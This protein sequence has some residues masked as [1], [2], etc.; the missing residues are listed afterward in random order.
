M[1]SRKKENHF[2][3]FGGA[4]LKPKQINNF[5]TNI[6]L[7]F[8]S[9]AQYYHVHPYC[10][11]CL[12]KNWKCSACY[13]KDIESS[14]FFYQILYIYKSYFIAMTQSARTYMRKLR[15]FLQQLQHENYFHSS[16]MKFLDKLNNFRMKSK[17]TTTIFILN[18]RHCDKNQK[19]KHIKL[20]YYERENCNEILSFVWSWA[21]RSIDFFVFGF[22]F[23][24][25]RSFIYFSNIFLSFSLSFYNFYHM[26]F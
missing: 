14:R 17:K 24:I 1:K 6:K 19:K 2:F 22:V 4:R 18:S 9:S 8:H 23:V 11:H 5:S 25:W 26:C 7:N 15:M 12:S 20:Y 10:D 3:P 13:K 21:A 16:I